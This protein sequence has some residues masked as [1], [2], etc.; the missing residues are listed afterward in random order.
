MNDSNRTEGEWN[1]IPSRPSLHVYNST[2]QIA[3]LAQQLCGFPTLSAG[4]PDLFTHPLFTKRADLF[5]MQRVYVEGEN[6]SVYCG[7]YERLRSFDELITAM[8]L[9]AALIA[10]GV[11][12]G[13]RPLQELIV[14][15]FP[16]MYDAPGGTVPLP[17]P[18]E[19]SIGNHAVVARYIGD[20][21]LFFWHTWGSRW[22]DNGIGSFSFEY[23]KRFQREAWSVRLLPGP[24]PENLVSRDP[25]VY[26]QRA[27]QLLSYPWKGQGDTGGWD[28]VR[29]G[30]AV[31]FIGRWLTAV[32]DGSPLLQCVAVLR[33]AEGGPL[34][35]GWMHIRE[36]QRGAEVEELFVWPRYRGRGIG[37]ALAGQTLFHEGV[38]FMQRRDLIWHQLESDVL[39]TKKAPLKAHVPRWLR[40]LPWAG[41]PR[42]AV[43]PYEERVKLLGRLARLKAPD[44]LRMRRHLWESNII[45]TVSQGGPYPIGKPTGFIEVAPVPDLSYSEFPG[46]GSDSL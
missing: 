38:V 16:S 1:F 34:M 12:F 42:V 31:D 45:G 46:I 19:R 40:N 25:S 30:S 21:R 22:G 44:G 18:D 20:E 7:L 24:V 36:T 11:E 17:D 27:A 15:I 43:L 29:R 4:L 28:L 3:T 13:R 35:V 23:L 9:E 26:E 6:A 8:H 37:T 10:R 5:N 32:G 41:S 14:Q 39:V 33:E 2:Q